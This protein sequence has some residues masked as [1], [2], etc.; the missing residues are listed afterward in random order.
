VGLKVLVADG[1]LDTAEVV[2]CGAR[3]VWPDCQ[4]SFAGTGRE[5]LRRF[6]GER[7]DLVVL[8]VAISTDGFEL[9]RSIRDASRAP[10]LV[11]SARGA[12][13]DKVRA[14]ELGADDYVTKPFE[15]LEL[16]ARLRALIRRATP[17]DGRP[18]FVVS[19]FS[20]DFLAHEVRVAGRPVVLTATEYR[21]LEELVRH[22][23][24]M[25]PNAL[26]VKR[27]WGA[28]SAHGPGNLKA[29]VRRVRAKLGDDAEQPTYIETVRGMGYR[30][31]AVPAQACVVPVTAA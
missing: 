22:A 4:I 7:P 25:L 24:T 17:P 28:G 16:L 19:G 21:L 23:G 27:V 11:L 15:Q 12:T 13:A 26:L 31:A 18:A 10:L 30:F 8:D 3:M 2:A 5:V 1:S 9:C 6:R 14:L 29:F 20:L